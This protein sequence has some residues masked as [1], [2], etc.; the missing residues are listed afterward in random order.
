MWF[1]T[2]LISGNLDQCRARGPNDPE[3]STMDTYTPEEHLCELLE[4]GGK[5][6]LMSSI[7]G[8]ISPFAS[9]P[10]LKLIIDSMDAFKEDHMIKLSLGKE[11]EDFKKHKVEDIKKLVTVH[12]RLELAESKRHHKDFIGEAENVKD[13][14]FNDKGECDAAQLM[15]LMYFAQENDH[16]SLLSLLF[17][18]L[19]LLP[20]ELVRTSL[21]G[22]L[23]LVQSDKKNIVFWC[24]EY[25]GP[26][27]SMILAKSTSKGLT[28]KIE[29]IVKGVIHWFCLVYIALDKNKMH[30]EPHCMDFFGEL[31][32][33]G[34]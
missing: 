2:A 19:E 22:I 31:L 25:L 11:D 24:L 23:S 10:D 21:Q 17:V 26:I 29:I 8:L 16:G 13:N 7:L 15:D 34:L 4:T 33:E 14:I 9:N 30:T 28:K 5:E 6:K 1:W 20:S 3:N 12:E 32:Q 27:A 18:A